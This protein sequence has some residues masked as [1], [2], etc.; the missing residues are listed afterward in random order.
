[1]FIFIAR[2][3]YCELW[4]SLQGVTDAQ[5]LKYARL[6]AKAIAIEF[7]GT[8]VTHIIIQHVS[9]QE[10][11]YDCAIFTA[12]HMAEFILG[13]Y[14]EMMDVTQLCIA[15][16][17][18]SIFLMIV[19]PLP[20]LCRGEYFLKSGPFHHVFICIVYVK[21]TPPPFFCHRDEDD[22][23]EDHRIGARVRWRARCLRST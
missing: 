21:L 18:I 7:P 3:R 17:R 22:L 1:M 2:D 13:L 23:K 11:G 12:R 6:L 4:F 10:N 14:K 15:A 8:L 5:Y 20:R 19:L 9:Q 16:H